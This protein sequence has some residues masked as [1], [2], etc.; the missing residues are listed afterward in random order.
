MIGHSGATGFD[1]DPVR[2]RWS[3]NSWVTG[4]NPAVNSLYARILAHNPAIRGQKFNLAINGSDVT[5]LVLQARKAV[6][7]K[8]TPEL[9]VV[10]SIDNDIACDGS[11]PRRLKPFGTAFSKASTSSPRALPT[12][13]SSSSASSAVRA[14]TSGR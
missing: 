6:T 4:D 3:H 12:R 13:E 2:A 8:P 7:M 11:D 5:S 14:P 10:Q 1:S 9:V